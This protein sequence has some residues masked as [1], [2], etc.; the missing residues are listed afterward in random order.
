M[1]AAVIHQLGTAPVYAEFDEPTPERGVVAHVVAASVKNIDRGLVSGRHYGSA[2]IALPSVAGVDGVARLDDGSLVYT[3]AVAPFGMMAERTVIDQA[4]AVAVPADIDPAV[5]AALPNPGLS[6]WFSLEY[7]GQVQPG[8][9]VVVLGATGVTGSVAVQLAKQVFDA[10]HVTVIGRNAARLEWLRAHGADDAITLGDDLTERVAAVHAARPI[11]VVIDY[12][13]G[14]PAERTLAA[15]GNTGF[16]AAHHGT[17]YVEVGSMAGPDI[18]LPSAIL[19]SAGV[20]LVGV[21]LGSIPE[22]TMRQRVGTE[23]LPRLFAMAADGTLD[24]QVQRVP[25]SDVERVWT[26]SEPSGT[27]VVLVP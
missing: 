4:R 15:L 24:L 12:L 19:R 17:R 5:A 10:G 25:L 13:W 6:A 23:I 26:E 8:A 20:Q 21:G 1:K 7:A 11:D 14:Q 2:S 16:G 22:S 9:H 18:T 3:G 27:R